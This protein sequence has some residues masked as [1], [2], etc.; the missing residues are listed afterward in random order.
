MDFRNALAKRRWMLPAGLVGLVIAIAGL[1]L[2]WDLTLALAEARSAF[3]APPGLMTWVLMG[4]G[5]LGVGVLA[6]ASL[7][8]LVV[9]TKPPAPR[10]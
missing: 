10:R 7:A 5:L 4:L 3:E 8:A 2:L 1:Q 9:G 6:I